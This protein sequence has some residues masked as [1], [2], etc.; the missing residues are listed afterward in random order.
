MLVKEIHDGDDVIGQIYDLTD[1]SQTSFPTP[2]HFALQF[3]EGYYPNGKA[4]IPHIHKRAERSLDATSEFI[5]MLSG[6][7]EVVFLSERNTVLARETFTEKMAF[8]QVRGGHKIT[9]NDNARYFELKQG[10]YK[11]RDFD[12][13]D[14]EDV[15]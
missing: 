12:K 9:F 8:L 2:E 14:V 7:M 10:P 5:F 13:Y 11:D 1:V 3:G 6:E 4:I 15:S